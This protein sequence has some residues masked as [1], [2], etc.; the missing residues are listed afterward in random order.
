M[1]MMNGLDGVDLEMMD[2]AFFGPPPRFLVEGHHGNPETE[3][4]V[5]RAESQSLFAGLAKIKQL[6]GV[7]Q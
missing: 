5:E 6:M 7:R 1:T 2:E 3:L 4:M